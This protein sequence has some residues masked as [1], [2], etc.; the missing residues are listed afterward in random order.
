[1]ANRIIIDGK[2]HRYS[3]LNT[4]FIQL[5]DFDLIMKIGDLAQE[6]DCELEIGREDYPDLIAVSFFMGVVDR[7]L[8]GSKMWEECLDFRSEF[9]G[10]KPLIVV[11][12]EN[13]LDAVKTRN[14]IY[15]KSHTE[16]LS[17]IT[18]RKNWLNR[19]EFI[20]YNS[21]YQWLSWKWSLLDLYWYEIKS[22]LSR[23]SDS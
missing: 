18:K 22:K 21:I 20:Y 14:I 19:I 12:T 5:D 10:N 11:D 2:A 7:R 23:D 16:I 1:M 4:L 6:L 9:G 8:V 15:A 3:W 13:G 17:I